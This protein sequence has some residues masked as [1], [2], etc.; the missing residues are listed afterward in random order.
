M[1][2]M[3]RKLNQLR[4]KSWNSTK[5]VFKKLTSTTI[6]KVI[7]VAAAIWLGGAALGAW[8]SG[9]GAVDG[10]LVAGGSGAGG[11]G[12][13]AGGAGEAIGTSAAASNAAAAASIPTGAEII[14]VTAPAAT[15]GGGTALAGGVASAAL[16]G[17]TTRPTQLPANTPT[18]EAASTKDMIAH[19]AQGTETK[20]LISKLMNPVQKLATW[21]ADNPLPA[22]M[23]VNGVGSAMSPDAIDLAKEQEE[24]DERTRQR[25]QDNLSVGSIDLGF[26]PRTDPLQYN[27][28]AP[29]FDPVTGAIS[30]NTRRA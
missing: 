21:G 24:Q 10:A 25:W 20:G 1:T 13:L 3:A 8:N 30:R 14:T 12:G 9:I 7:L 11:A 23:L 18:P 16:P 28:G 17:A 15:G 4:K 19:G 27:N 6:G 29:V 26:R 5:K 22:M 2:G